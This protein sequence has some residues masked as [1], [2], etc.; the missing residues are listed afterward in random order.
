MLLLLIKCKFVYE[1]I[2]G[3]ALSSEFRTVVQCLVFTFLYF[4]LKICFVASPLQFGF[5]NL[6]LKAW[7]APLFNTCGVS[8]I[9]LSSIFSEKVK[10][11][12]RKNIGYSGNGLACSAVG[13]F[14][15]LKV[16]TADTCV[17]QA[18]MFLAKHVLSTILLRES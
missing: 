6:C 3:I 12:S 5:G 15:I 14:K 16:C 10:S 13:T 9:V 8:T 4:S 18:L 11:A 1:P 17:A 7:I 2:K